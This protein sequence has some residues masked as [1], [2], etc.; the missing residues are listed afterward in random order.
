MHLNSQLALFDSLANIFSF[1]LIALT[2]DPEQK[3]WLKPLEIVLA[4]K[5]KA[6]L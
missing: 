6:Y 1:I 3:P 4:I 2:S 5:S